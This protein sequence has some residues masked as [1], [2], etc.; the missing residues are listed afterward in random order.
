MS[1]FKDMLKGD[2]SLFRNEIALDYDFLPKL[3]PYRENEQRHLAT[4][5]AP[6][7]NGRNGKN[8]FIFGAPGIGKTAAM[9]FVFRDLEE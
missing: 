6:L 7:L 8:L 9:K 2:E 5:I 3:L 1:L 4:C